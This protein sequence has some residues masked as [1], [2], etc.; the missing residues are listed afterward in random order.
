MSTQNNFIGIYENLYSEEFCNRMIK[1]YEDVKEA[2]FSCNKDASE[3]VVSTSREDETIFPVSETMLSVPATKELCA[4]FNAIF[5]GVAYADY[6]KQFGI[7][8]TFDPHSIHTARLQKTVV[9]AGYH[10]WHCENPTRETSGRV[11]VWTLYLNDVAEGGETE[12]L[13]QHLRVKPKQGT[14][15]IWPAGFTHTHRG[16]PPLSNTKYIFTGWVEY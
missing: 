4:D 16:N 11:L 15:V 9:G 2:G 10:I 14:L 3:H 12:Y 1:Y 6:L 5:W 8:Q 7:L 13:Y